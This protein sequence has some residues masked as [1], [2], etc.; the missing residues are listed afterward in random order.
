MEGFALWRVGW[1]W[2]SWEGSE[3]TTNTISGGGGI[4]I[5]FADTGPGNRDND[6]QMSAPS[7]HL[8]PSHW[9]ALAYQLFACIIVMSSVLC[10]KQRLFLPGRAKRRFIHYK[11][12]ILYKNFHQRERN[13]AQYNSVL[14]LGWYDI[15][16]ENKD[17]SKR[18]RQNR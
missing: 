13:E 18:N 15:D 4:Q 2:A 14:I 16:I 8:P 1:A 3:L 5:I 11:N 10:D 9:P 6:K 17:N 12:N 7:P